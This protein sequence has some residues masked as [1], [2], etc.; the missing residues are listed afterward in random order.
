[1]S[2]AETLYFIHRIPLLSA[3]SLTEE[4]LIRRSLLFDSS[5]VLE[6]SVEGRC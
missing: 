6:I 4:R 1:M 5:P 2:V 3:F